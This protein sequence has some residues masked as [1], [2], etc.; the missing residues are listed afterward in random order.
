MLMYS[1]AQYQI[2]QTMQ[3]TVRTRTTKIDPWSA[4]TSIHMPFRLK[5]AEAFLRNLFC[6]PCIH[7]AENFAATSESERSLKLVD[8]YVDVTSWLQFYKLDRTFSPGA[9]HSRSE[10]LNAVIPCYS[11]EASTALVCRK[12]P[13][14]CG[15]SL[16]LQP[17]IAWKHFFHGSIALVHVKLYGSLEVGNQFVA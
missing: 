2:S 17:R 5:T 12:L 10:T 8:N 11:A 4:F 1:D 14:I 16:G 7:H 9:I 15:E 13:L 6:S 3:T